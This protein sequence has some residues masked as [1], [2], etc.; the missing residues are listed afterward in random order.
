MT[1][2]L[3]LQ[4]NQRIFNPKAKSV[5]DKYRILDNITLIN[6]VW[7]SRK[8]FKFVSKVGFKELL[9]TRDELAFVRLINMVYGPGNYCIKCWGKGKETGLRLFWDGLILEDKFY[10]KRDTTIVSSA[11]GFYGRTSYAKHPA[12]QISKYMKTEQPG[13]WHNL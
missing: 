4:L 2:K 9:I 1:R 8:Y 12:P 11:P 5:A 7:R 10:R 13:K 3:T 6:V